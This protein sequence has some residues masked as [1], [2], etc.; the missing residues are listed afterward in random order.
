MKKKKS[1]LKKEIEIPEGIEVK[2][3]EGIINIK[4]KGGELSKDIPDKR[5]K[6]ELI[7]NKIILSSKKTS[8]NNK[9]I[10]SSSSTHIK[11]MLKGLSKEFKYKLKICSGHFPM[12]VNVEGKKLKIKNFLGEKIPREAELLDGVKVEVKGSEII[13][14]GPGIEKVGQTASNIEQST[15][16][17]NKDKR[18]FQDGIYITEKPK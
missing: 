1:E 9:R 6:I 17:T 7:N 4:G 11:N 10:M 15:R 8:K 14:E 16:I 5:I 3:E 2:I 18:I 12:S 13:V